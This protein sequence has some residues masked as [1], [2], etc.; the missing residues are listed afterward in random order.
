MAISLAFDVVFS[1]FVSLLL[2][3][4]TIATGRRER[5]E[6]SREAQNVR[7]PSRANLPACP[8][9]LLASAACAAARRAIGTR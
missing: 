4:E 6:P 9:Q 3:R 2:V 7:T 8:R 1:T 5:P